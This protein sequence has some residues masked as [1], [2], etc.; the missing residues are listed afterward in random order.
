MAKNTITKVMANG[1][2]VTVPN[3]ASMATIKLASRLLGA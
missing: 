3:N 2:K 1:I